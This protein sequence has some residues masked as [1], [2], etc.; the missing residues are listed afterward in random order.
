MGK[1]GMMVGA[2]DVVRLHVLVHGAVGV[3][4]V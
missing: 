3:E 2:R 1:G 4:V